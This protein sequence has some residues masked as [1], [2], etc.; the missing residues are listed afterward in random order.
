MVTTADINLNKYKSLTLL[1]FL[2][3]W[4]RGFLDTLHHLVDKHMCQLSDEIEHD[5]YT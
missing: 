3:G 1:K 5:R 4:D 2:I